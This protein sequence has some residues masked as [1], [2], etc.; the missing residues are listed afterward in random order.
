MEAQRPNVLSVRPPLASTAAEAAT[1]T[2]TSHS[3]ES[4]RRDRKRGVEIP[5]ILIC[6][7]CG[8]KAEAKC[9]CGATYI[10]ASKLAE[11][12]VIANPE[13]SDR[14]LAAQLGVGKDVV[15]RARVLTGAKAPVKTRTGKDG[16]T[17]VMPVKLPRPS[18]SGG[19]VRLTEK[20]NAGDAEN[21]PTL[22]SEYFQVEA[23]AGHRNQ[24]IDWI[25]DLARHL[26][27]DP[28]PEEAR[29]VVESIGT[30]A[31]RERFSAAVA[32]LYEFVGQ[33]Q[34][35]LHERRIEEPAPTLRAIP[36]GKDEP[37]KH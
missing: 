7:I 21:P 1:M 28:S 13:L 12:A 14:A 26:P 15:R 9:A 27:R 32:K 17:R 2:K 22:T 20:R 6:S 36:G 24:L 34:R 3:K 8:A 5:Q 11:R 37:T 30:E 10:P 23:Q 16:K 25:V 35:A 4:K 29:A 33:L 18:S 31:M 19:V